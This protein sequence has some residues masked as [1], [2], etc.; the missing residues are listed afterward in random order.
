MRGAGL[1]IPAESVRGALLAARCLSRRGVYG[2]AAGGSSARAP[3]ARAPGR[4]TEHE[5]L[6][7]DEVIEHRLPRAVAVAARDRL[8]NP[9]VVLMRARRPARRVERLLAPPPH[10]IPHPPHA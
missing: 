4:R 6:D 2:A 10:Q 9:P 7:G 3:A 5:R 8:E 1:A